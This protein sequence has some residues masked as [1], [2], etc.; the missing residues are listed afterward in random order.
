M[1]KRQ[2]FFIN[3]YFKIIMGNKKELKKN[4]VTSEMKLLPWSLFLKLRWI[5]LLKQKINSLK[6]VFGPLQ[7]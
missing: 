5:F 2:F 3:K 6:K 7:F 1:F 4:T